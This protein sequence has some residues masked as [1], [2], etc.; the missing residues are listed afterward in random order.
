MCQILF[1]REQRS[2]GHTL[3]QHLGVGSAAGGHR[4]ALQARFLLIGRQQAGHQFSLRRHMVRRLLDRCLHF[5]ALQARR[6]GFLQLL[7]VGAHRAPHVQRTEP[8]AV[9][10][11]QDAHIAGQRL[12]YLIPAGAAQALSV[13]LCAD[14]VRQHR[15]RSFRAQFFQQQEHHADGVPLAFR[16]GAVSRDPCG[17]NFHA[18]VRH[19]RGIGQ[20]RPVRVGLHLFR[21]F[22]SAFHQGFAFTGNDVDP[23][24][25][26]QLQDF[27]AAFRLGRVQF[28]AQHALL[29]VDQR[30]HGVRAEAHIRNLLMRSVIGHILPVAFLVA[31]EDQPDAFLQRNARFLNSLHGKERRQGW[32]FIVIGSPAVHPSVFNQRLERRLCPSVSHGYHVQVTQHRDFF[33]RFAQRDIAG[34]AV[35]VPYRKSQF[36]GVFHGGIQHVPDFPSEGSAVFRF[37]LHGRNPYPALQHL[38]KIIPVTVNQFIYFL[39]H[40]FPASCLLSEASFMFRS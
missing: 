9:F 13:M 1:V 8:A 33:F 31:A 10:Q 36:P 30:E 22:P 7:L 24:S 32:A 14:L 26:G 16:I 2:E 4:L 20:L 29:R 34:I 6:C 3:L 37:A 5:K 18:P 35:K 27:Q 39:F 23:V 21:G 28:Q 17:G 12:G 11:L 19:F 15:N 38:R 25:G 40:H